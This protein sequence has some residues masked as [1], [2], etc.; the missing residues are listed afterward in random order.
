HPYNRRP[1]LD[2]EVDKLRFLCVYLN[3]AEE[4]ERRKQYSN[5]Y[6]N[7]LELA[8]F[9]FKSD[10][11]WLSDYFYKKCLSL[12]QTYSQLDSQLVA[13]AYRNVARVYERR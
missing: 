1:L 9:F 7:Y 12:A 6:K 10:D 5:V 11:H 2:A 8:S 13:E 4:A 3:K